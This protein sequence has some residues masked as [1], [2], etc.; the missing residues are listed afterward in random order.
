LISWPALARPIAF[1]IRRIATFNRPIGSMVVRISFFSSSSKFRWLATWSARLPGPD[2]LFL[3]RFRISPG[4]RGS[5]WMR[6]SRR[7]RAFPISM[8]ASIDSSSFSSMQ[9][10]RALRYGSVWM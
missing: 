8:F 6:F 4:T 1:S 2:R 10:T 7:C 5:S 9:A 3:I